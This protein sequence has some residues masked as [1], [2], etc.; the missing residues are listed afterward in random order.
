MPKKV[1]V[2]GRVFKELPEAPLAGFTFIPGPP[3]APRDYVY[4]QE[5][6]VFRSLVG[7][8]FLLPPS[9]PCP[10]S[11]AAEQLRKE[12]QLTLS[13]INVT[14]EQA[15]YRAHLASATRGQLVGQGTGEGED[16]HIVVF[17]PD[18][19]GAPEEEESAEVQEPSTKRQRTEEA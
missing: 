15:R 8:P 6:L 17:V 10:R 9:K 2:D 3:V 1:L 4:T 16:K 12:Y 7:L 19:P 13:E 5:E 18:D 14:Y 11:A